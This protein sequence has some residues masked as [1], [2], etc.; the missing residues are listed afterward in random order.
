MFHQQFKIILFQQAFKML[1]DL[2]FAY[3]YYIFSIISGEGL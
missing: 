3:V 2:I 1:T